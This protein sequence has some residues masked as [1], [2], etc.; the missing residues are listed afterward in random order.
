MA[1]PMSP[2][3]RAA[4]GAGG[5]AEQAFPPPGL[6]ECL[7]RVDPSTPSVQVLVMCGSS[8]LYSYKASIDLWCS[9]LRGVHVSA[10]HTTMPIARNGDMLE[11]GRTHI[12]I[13]TPGRLAALVRQMPCQF[14]ST[15]FLLVA[16]LDAGLRSDAK[17]LASKLAADVQVRCVDGTSLVEEQAPPSLP[18]GGGPLGVREES[19][20]QAEEQDVCQHLLRMPHFFVRAHDQGKLQHLSS[21]LD[22]VDFE[23]AV[24]F[25]NTS[26]QASELSRTLVASG[27]P[28]FCTHAGLDPESRGARLGAF[29]AF[30]K[31][32]LVTDEIASRCKF[33]RLDLLVNFDVPQDSVA[34]AHRTECLGKSPTAVRVVSIAASFADEATLTSLRELLGVDVRLV[35][36]GCL[37][38]TDS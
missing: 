26:Q 17:R 6:A 18:L 23:Q 36:G 9:R 22:A 4:A 31:R 13:G 1:C 33:P 19:L 5:R 32:I 29:A 25:T 7:E 38:T 16:A 12:L 34:Y 11:R 14:K 8:D 28:V 37:P 35:A 2:G 24:V 10:V 21:V 27:Y 20:Q 3:P 15:R 30:E